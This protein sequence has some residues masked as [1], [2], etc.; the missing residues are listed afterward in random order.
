MEIDGPAIGTAPAAEG[1][2]HLSNVRFDSLRGTIDERTLRSVPFEFM[3]EVQ[4]SGTKQRYRSGK[5]WRRGKT[6]ANSSMTRRLLA[7]TASGLYLDYNR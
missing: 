6:S 2:S 3:T 1:T 7:V 4:V 5:F